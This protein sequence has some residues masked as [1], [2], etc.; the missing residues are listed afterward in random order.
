MSGTIVEVTA[1]DVESGQ[2]R[3]GDG[4]KERENESAEEDENAREEKGTGSHDGG[5]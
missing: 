1:H 3:E 2:V 4:D 5:E